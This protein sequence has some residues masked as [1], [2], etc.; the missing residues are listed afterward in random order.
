MREIFKAYSLSFLI[1]S[2]L[3]F[4]FF[5]LTQRLTLSEKRLIEIDLSLENLQRQP[6]TDLSQKAQPLP[7]RPPQTQ[8]VPQ[9]PIPPTKEEIKSSTMEQSKQEER[10]I[11]ATS[12]PNADPLQKAQPLPAR[13]LQTQPVP[14]ATIPPTKEEIKSPTAKQ[15]KQEEKQSQVQSPPKPAEAEI[16]E[17]QTSQVQTL[18]P[19]KE[20]TKSKT[21]EHLGQGE[22]PLQAKEIT[23]K[24]ASQERE[25]KEHQAQ[26]N[27][28]VESSSRPTSSSTHTSPYP[29]ES[30]KLTDESKRLALEESFL[31]ERLSVIS[32]I[33]QRHINYPPIARRM[34]WEGKVLVSF[35]LEPNG[36]IR[37]LKVLK[38][39][40]YEVLDKEALDAIRRSYRDFPKP[41]VSVVVKLPINFRLE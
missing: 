15:L 2:L 32:N 7:A 13:L 17:T 23:Q 27:K 34:G 41:P 14:Q 12:P 39:S 9:A 28:S 26:T 10:L 22:R 8:P 3:L 30:S 35:V 16:R 33:V 40:G 21:A 20:E 1:H 5:L 38:S 24:P 37:D 19:L 31:R 6:Q 36:N 29:S 18:P 11:Q 25:G 4:G